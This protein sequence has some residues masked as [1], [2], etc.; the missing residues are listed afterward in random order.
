MEALREGEE[1]SVELVVLVG[2]VKSSCGDI[3][4]AHVGTGL[5]LARVVFSGEP[6]HIRG[7]WGHHDTFIAPALSPVPTARQHPTT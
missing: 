1:R 4:K 2:L 3:G 6:A 7:H 5:G